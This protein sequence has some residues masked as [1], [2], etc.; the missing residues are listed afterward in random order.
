[1]FNAARGLVENFCIYRTIMELKQGQGVVVLP[2]VH[3]IYR[4]IMELKQ[5]YDT[6]QQ[7]TAE[8]LSNHHGIETV[9]EF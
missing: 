1:M 6:V 8:Y 9:K 4:T 3:R 7:A 5:D 2:L